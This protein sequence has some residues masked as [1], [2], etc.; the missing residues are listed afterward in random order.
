[1]L[2]QARAILNSPSAFHLPS[3]APSPCH[4][5]IFQERLHVAIHASKLSAHGILD[6]HKEPTTLLIYHSHSRTLP[7]GL[8]LFQFS[9]TRIHTMLYGNFLH[10]CTKHVERMESGK[11]ILFFLLFLFGA[12]R[13]YTKERMVG[14]RFSRDGSDESGIG[15][16]FAFSA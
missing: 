11:I 3:K 10:Y 8:F 5:L 9:C 12:L 15:W 1:M 4:L 13:L 6:T 16:L 7:N 2:P 14:W